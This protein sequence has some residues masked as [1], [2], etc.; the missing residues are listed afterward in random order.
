MTPNVRRLALYAKGNFMHKLLYTAAIPLLVSGTMAATFEDTAGD[1][2]TNS[3]ATSP[4]AEQD[5]G[6]SS[7]PTETKPS[8]LDLMVPNL[9]I[10][11]I[12]EET[13]D[14]AGLTKELTCKLSQADLSDLI[15]NLAI[16]TIEEETPDAAGTASFTFSAD[17]SSQVKSLCLTDAARA[18]I[19]FA[20][21]S[22]YVP[23]SKN[24]VFD[25][26]SVRD[27][28]SLTIDLIFSAGT[29]EAASASYTVAKSYT[30]QIPE[31]T[32][33]TQ[34]T[35]GLDGLSVLTE[36]LPTE[37][38]LSQLI[39]KL[40]VSDAFTVTETAEEYSDLPPLEEATGVSPD[41]E[42]ENAADADN[43]GAPQS[44]ETVDGS[45]GNG[46]NIPAVA[47]PTIDAS[48]ANAN[49]GGNWDDFQ[50]PEEPA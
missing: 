12:E 43:S 26:I 22:N 45:L 9:A 19:P 11:T 23:G 48:D 44:E 17:V 7:N 50:T 25:A 36:L 18:R 6:I 39:L 37:D 32:I 35:G 4:A 34:P 24:T 38:G 40:T 29:Y 28:A 41:E 30:G 31:V 10:N 1:T 2:K 5:D 20:L 8:Y 46:D 13:P 33:K 3:R 42:E 21:D 47:A 14:A 49:E 15:P 27:D 16:K